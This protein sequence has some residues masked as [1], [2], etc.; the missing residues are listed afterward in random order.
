MLGGLD[1][2]FRAAAQKGDVA[3]LEKV[4]NQ[5]PKVL[6]S[7][8]PDTGKTALHRAAENGRKEA[9]HWLVQHGAD[10]H[11]KAADG[12][13]VF[14]ST[15]NN[16]QFDLFTFIYNHANPHRPLL[17]EAPRGIVKNDSYTLPPLI[18]YH[19]HRNDIFFRQ[20]TM[21]FSLLR[22]LGYQAVCYEWDEGISLENVL[23]PESNTEDLFHAG[24]T[25]RNLL[26]NIALTEFQ[27]HGI[28]LNITAAY[29]RTIDSVPAMRSETLLTLRSRFFAHQLVQH[30]N[31]YQG[32]II[33]FI[34]KGHVKVANELK[35]MGARDGLFKSFWTDPSS[36]P[37]EIMMDRMSL[38]QSDKMVLIPRAAKLQD[39]S[40][41]II[42]PI[43]EFKKNNPLK[44]VIVSESATSSTLAAPS[45]AAPSS[46][47]T[48]P[49]TKAP[50]E[51][52]AVSEPRVPEF[53]KFD[54]SEEAKA[55]LNPLIKQFEDALKSKPI[56]G[57]RFVA[58]LWTWRDALINNKVSQTL[59]LQ[60]TVA[61]GLFITNERQVQRSFEGTPE[62]VFLGKLCVLESLLRY[63]NIVDKLRENPVEAAEKKALVENIQIAFSQYKYGDFLI[64]DSL[65]DDQLLSKTKLQLLKK[66][67]QLLSQYH[68]QWMGTKELL[69]HIERKNKQKVLDGQ[70]YCEAIFNTN[71]HQI[72]AVDEYCINK[73]VSKMVAFRTE[74]R[75][76][77]QF[78]VDVAGQSHA[79]LF[80]VTRGTDNRT[81]N[82]I[83]VEST[84]IP[85][86]HLAIMMMVSK[87]LMQGIKPNIIA[88]QADLQKD[89][90]SCYAFALALSTILAK[91]SF[92]DLNKHPGVVPEFIG[93]DGKKIEL[94][95]IEEVKWV[96][97]TLLGEKAVMMGQSST[98]MKER[99]KLLAPTKEAD[100]EAKIIKWQQFYKIDGYVSE[101][102][103]QS[104][105]HYRRRS[106]RL[107][108]LQT[109]FA[110][111][112]VEKVLARTKSENVG[113]ALRRQASG[114][115]PLRDMRYLLQMHPEI[116][117][118]KGG[119][120]QRTALYWAYT[121]NQPNRIRLLKEAGASEDK[122]GNKKVSPENK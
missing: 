79:L 21:Q 17:Q 36:D 115:G 51:P 14:C 63:D 4:W 8:G 40:Q 59:R 105:I 23:A 64:G 112:S 10:Y 66:I 37:L 52:V 42:K 15:L 57:S 20:I 82:I 109:P 92:A 120:E 26:Q 95:V 9:V 11:V 101:R 19:E 90:H 78:I 48:T 116:I 85:L 22:Q 93:V 35:S 119:T 91:T 45:V 25:T 73:L 84:N 97:V 56:Y 111:L 60:A 75:A 58:P 27:Y 38:A 89:S 68:P 102:Y 16:Q 122:A 70:Y 49:T 86:Q 50:T 41:F 88:I 104:Y 74:K 121:K 24:P 76:K 80:D 12:I 71:A 5:D 54:S 13:S 69:F 87:L 110:D 72:S 118:E 2:K 62:A 53:F 28:D 30:A 29:A 31:T 43:E 32:G 96:P 117:N 99:L 3:T 61:V 106:W 114:M 103:P 1:K 83:C 33:A 46:T 18:F 6:N 44:P 107:R 65:N 47:M 34:S 39:L 100:V 113:Q 108:Y 81:L 98:Q 55:F 7:Q 77:R 94:F 67:R